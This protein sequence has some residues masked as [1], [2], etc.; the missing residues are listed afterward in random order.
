MTATWAAIAL[1]GTKCTVAVARTDRQTIDWLGG[2]VIQTCSPP[3]QM[4]SRLADALARQLAALGLGSVDGIGIV[5]GSPLNEEAGLVLAPPNLPDWV[6]VDVLTPFERRFRVRPV[7]IND[8]DAGALA[9]WA[10]GAARGASNVVF[11]TVGT[12]LGAGLI[13]GGRL[14]RG[15]S[16]LAGEI[17]HW[18]LAPDG[19]IGHG[20]VG[21]FEGFCAGSGIARQA[22]QL[23]AQQL[24]DGTPGLL[25]PDWASVADMSARRAGTAADQGDTV[26]LALWADVGRRLGAG[27]ALLVDVLNPDVIVLGG[28]YNRQI[29]RL[30][31]PMRAVLE[32]EALAAS[33]RVC[34]IVP[35]ALGERIGDWSGL[36]AALVGDRQTPTGR[37]ITEAALAASPSP[38]A[39][40]QR[41]S[42][43]ADGQVRNEG[44]HQ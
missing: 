14:Y 26:A 43:S 20:K 12:G 7:L 22:Q 25:G 4:L 17:G 6:A 36:A 9:E 42:S 34:R 44:S 5:C 32:R 19:P 13:L 1:G 39:Q 23:A 3:A 30:E 11:L 31:P 21:S 10:W 35:S 8:A 38:A 16:G 37:L 15:A 33:L 29:A 28:I 41:I 27:L 18:R 40:R 2:D 24:S